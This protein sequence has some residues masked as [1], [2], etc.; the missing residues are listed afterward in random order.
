MRLEL[1]IRNFSSHIL[2]E[3]GLSPQMEYA[4]R[5]DLRHPLLSSLPVQVAQED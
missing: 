1:A 5:H 3:R 2:A 4:Y